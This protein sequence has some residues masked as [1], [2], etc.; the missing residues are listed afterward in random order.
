[1][2]FEIIQ[3]IS[4]ICLFYLFSNKTTTW[5]P[6]RMSTII[7][8]TLIIWALEQMA[9]VRQIDWTNDPI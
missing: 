5:Q 7:P 4:I 2:F 1:M 8:D 3:L 6:E 9:H